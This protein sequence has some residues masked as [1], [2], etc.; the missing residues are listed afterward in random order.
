MRE[1]MR[2]RPAMLVTHTFVL[3]LLMCTW[4]QD[5]AQAQFSQ[6]FEGKMVVV[7]IDMPGTQLGVDLYPQRDTPLDVKSYAKRLKEYG[8]AVRVGDEVMIT[9]IKVK[10]K[11]I[12]VQLGG[13][14]Y[15][16][17]WDD[18][19]TR[20]PVRATEKSWREKDLEAQLKNE[21]D[22]A[23]RKQLRRKLDDQRD[24]R[25]SE[26][27]RNQSLSADA[28]V[29]K[30]EVINAKRLQGGSRF[31][32]RYTGAVPSEALT[33]EAVMAAL[34]QYVTFPR[35]SFGSGADRR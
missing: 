17:A 5:G 19:D 34:A 8:T 33:R 25:E 27:R 26:D 15:G 30:E 31:N 22:S 3:L 24:R 16:T 1:I 29:R 28:S 11:L 20:V 23:K 10:D 4:L 18:T 9:K 21:T 2:D 13:G 35:S 6:A 14:G 7:K 12:E 32:L